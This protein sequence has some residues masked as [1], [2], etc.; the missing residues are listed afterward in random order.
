MK[1]KLLIVS[2]YT[3]SG[4][5]TVIEKLIKKYKWKKYRNT[6]RKKW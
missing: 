1:N 4:K 3:S 2:G 6:F 5:N